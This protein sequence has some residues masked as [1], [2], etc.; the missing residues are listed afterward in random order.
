[1]TKELPFQRK[2]INAV[3]ECGGWG[4][5]L[6]NQFTSG[7]P[8]LVLQ[9]PDR[10]KYLVEV[11]MVALPVRPGDMLKVA[12][13]VLQKK[14]ILD[15]QGA[16]GST[17]VLVCHSTP[18]FDLIYVTRNVTT[19]PTK[20]EFLAKCQTRSRGQPLSILVRLQLLDPLLSQFQRGYLMR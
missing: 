15:D 5:K 17:G 11:K 13:T 1:M 9:L 6:S 18:K 7:I 3:K 12:L 2:I 19:M 10:P 4:C 16:G 20:E 14:T 8:D